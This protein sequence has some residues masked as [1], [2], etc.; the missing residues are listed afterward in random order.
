MAGSRKSWFLRC[1]FLVIAAELA[2]IGIAGAEIRLVTREAPIVAIPRQ[3]FSETFTVSPD[4]RSIAFA[5]AKGQSAAVLIN[6]KEMKRYSNIG[7]TAFVFSPDSKHLA[8]PVTKG[9]KWTVAV[10]GTEGG[11]YDG[12]GTT[13]AF[14]S[15]SQRLAYGVRKDKKWLVIMGKE[16]QKE[17]GE[18]ILKGTPIFSPDG[19]RMEFGKARSGSW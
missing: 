18:A 7:M 19:K 5:A 2:L 1:T 10:D 4:C 6:G 14:S 3:I 13:L 11:L 8:H 12:I 15:D 17:E 9:P 16:A